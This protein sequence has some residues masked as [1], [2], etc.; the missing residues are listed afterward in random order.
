MRLTHRIHRWWRQ[1]RPRLARPRAGRPVD[2]YAVAL[3]VADQR[4]KY[5]TVLVR[6][7]APDAAGTNDGG[8]PAMRTPAVPVSEVSR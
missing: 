6:S 5:L 1:P 8:G 4:R 7:T 2:P 3:H